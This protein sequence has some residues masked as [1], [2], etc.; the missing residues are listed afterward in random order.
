[1]N[2][3]STL[4]ILAGLILTSCSSTKVVSPASTVSAVQVSSSPADALFS[5]KKSNM[6]L[7]DNDLFDQ[8]KEHVRLLLEQSKIKVK[9][10]EDEK[11]DTDTAFQIGPALEKETPI[12]VI[13]YADNIFQDHSATLNL[14]LFLDALFTPTTPTQASFFEMYTSA[15]A[16]EPATL[17]TIAKLRKAILT[18]L[19]NPT[20][21]VMN[22]SQ[23]NGF[24]TGES[25]LWEMK[26]NEYMKLEKK[27]KT[28]KRKPAQNKVAP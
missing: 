21:Y 17:V 20:C 23:Y 6:S 18:R 28:E 11:L 12:I 25:S 16:N 14:T 27:L 1:M 7:A 2:R 10:I 9:W 5:F 22:T 13:K 8:A 26:I 24:V 19:D 3:I 4:A 15:V